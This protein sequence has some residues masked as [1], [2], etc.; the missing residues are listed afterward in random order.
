MRHK[1]LLALLLIVVSAVLGATALREPLAVAASP[2]Q[3]VL[4][5]N[6]ADNPVPVKQQG[7]ADVNVTNT[8]GVRP[9]VPAGAFSVVPSGSLFLVSGPDPAGTGYAITSF[10]VNNPTDTP[11]IVDVFAAY[12]NTNDCETFSG[13]PGIPLAGPRVVVPTGDT[14]HL[15]FPQPFVFTVG[16]APRVYVSGHWAAGPSPRAKPSSSATASRTQPAGA[17][18]ASIPPPCPRG[19]QT[20]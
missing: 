6:T 3:N 15:D 19:P 9:A 5:G 17:A 18:V 20:A 14:V 12:G 4:V 7:T 13:A 1:V 10:T 11:K 16:E 8:L 2:F